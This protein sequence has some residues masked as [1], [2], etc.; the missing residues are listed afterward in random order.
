MKRLR[1]LNFAGQPEYVT[2]TGTGTSRIKNFVSTWKNAC[3]QFLTLKN[4][5]TAQGLVFPSLLVH[6]IGNNEAFYLLLSV[7]GDRSIP[8]LFD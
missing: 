2:L 4:I 1:P 8:Y 5:S 3:H 6:C 7:V